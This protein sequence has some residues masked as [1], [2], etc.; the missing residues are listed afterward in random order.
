[1]GARYVSSDEIYRSVFTLEKKDPHRMNGF[2]LLV[3]IGTDPRRTDKFYDRLDP[4]L[5]DL[6]GK[7]YNFVSIT[8]LLQGSR[9]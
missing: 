8:E 4:L 2:I 1:M 5:R 6:K 7:G 9:R 3:H